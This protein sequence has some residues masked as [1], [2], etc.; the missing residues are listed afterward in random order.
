MK[1]LTSAE[2]PP[3]KA[4]RA[5]NIELFRVF[6]MLLIVMHH[7]VVNSGLSAAEGPIMTNYF[8]WKSQFLLLFGGWG[9]MGINCFVLIT[10]YFMCQSKI[11]LQK[12]FKLLLQVEFYSIVLACIF[13]A[14]G[15]RHLTP[16]A[17][18]YAIWPIWSISN[19]FVHCFLLFYFLIPYL[20][21][22]IQHIGHRQHLYLM[23]FLVMM[24]SFL[25]TFVEKIGWGLR[26]N[27]VSWFCVI[28]L[29]GSYIR[30]YQKE[31]FSGTKKWA[32]ISVGVFA[33]TLFST[34]PGH[35]FKHKYWDFFFWDCH[36]PFALLLAV[37]LFCLFKNLKIPY[38][39]WINLL[40][41]TS[42]GVLLIH[43][44]SDAMRR[45]LWK[46]TLNNVGAYDSPYFLLHVFGSVLA[47]YLICTGIDWLRIRFIEKPFFAWYQ[48]R[49]HG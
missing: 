17:V 46:D 31:F 20:N 16:R 15:Y 42:F 40:G 49:F 14:T 11:S 33:L 26:L 37:S 4:P 38:S 43:A 21:T 23:G 24:Y 35:L 25:G 45:W 22:L 27:Y 48:R 10:G 47:I 36:R 44:N 41:A 32:L 30:L 9:K 5:S 7:Y 1:A 13:W 19:N 18:L 39:K 6:S 8:S 12:F 34:I 3:S 28:Y 29:I 2:N